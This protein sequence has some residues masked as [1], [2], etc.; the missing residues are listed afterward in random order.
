M[1]LIKRTN[2]LKKATG[3]Y[4]IQSI[5]NGKIYIG[6]ALNLQK[7][8]SSH[9]SALKCKKHGN[10]HL[11]KHNNKYGITDL[12]FSVLEFCVKEKLI[13]REQFYI[14]TLQPVFNIRKIADSSLGIKASEEAKRKMSKAKM[15]R[16]HPL[17]GKH[18]SKETR[19]KISA[20][21]IAK[22]TGENHP[23]FGKRH[24]KEAKE[25]MSL[26][27]IGTNKGVENPFFGKHHSDETR[28]K[29]K[30][31]QIK[32]RE[33]EQKLKCGCVYS[34]YDPDKTILRVC[35]TH[36]ERYKERVDAGEAMT[37]ESIKGRVGN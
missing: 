10:P 19:E 9:L 18:S 3:I 8:K 4:Q 7:R 16:N 24:S 35:D 34:C 21:R 23:M 31:A 2:I 36:R 20:I 25:K 15:G 11:Q 26:S 1:N 13:E 5:K 6:S 29:M 27:R 22:Y 12:Q 17:F 14:D 30:K 33:E 28:K 37:V 32:R